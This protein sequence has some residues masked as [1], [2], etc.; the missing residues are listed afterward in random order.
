MTLDPAKI[1]AD[2][3]LTLMGA[4]GS[5]YTRKMLAVLRYRQLPYR[6]LLGNTASGAGAAGLPQPKVPLLPTFFLKGA[7]GQLE[8]VTD[9][10]PLIRRFERDFAGR[11]VV[12]ADPV[13][14]LLDA[15][16]EDYGDEWLTK[17]M[18]HYRWSYPADVAKSAAVLPTWS[19]P[20]ASD[21]VLGQAARQFSE[22]QI[23]RL[24]YVG[25]SAATAPIIEAAYGR[26]LDAF[27][28][29]LRE[30]MFLLGR[31]PAPAISACMAS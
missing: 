1:L 15:L 9:S 22:R 19:R 2:G 8:A 7:D 28:A 18:F 21:E 14:A 5:P 27:E 11:E 31:D 30:H 12:P 26:F 3:R 10:T 4:P 24:R 29:H 17:A 20:P 6:L 16:L 23:G 13:L 25:S